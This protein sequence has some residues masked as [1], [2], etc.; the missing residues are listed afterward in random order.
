[1]AGSDLALHEAHNQLNTMH[2]RFNALAQVAG[3]EMPK[4]LKPA[5]V[6]PLGIAVAAA[7]A[8]GEAKWGTKAMIANSLVAAVAYGVGIMS[9]DNADLRA[10]AYMFATSLGSAAASVAAYDGVTNWIAK[11]S[12]PAAAPGGA[13]VAAA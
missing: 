12:A 13:M 4:Y 11:Q 10:G 8:A 6:A 2:E 5:V 9:G 3:R 1:M 7:A